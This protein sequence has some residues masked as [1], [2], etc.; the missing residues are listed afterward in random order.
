MNM[1]V[2]LKSRKC[3]ALLV[4]VTIGTGTQAKMRIAHVILIISLNILLHAVKKIT[5]LANIDSFAVLSD[6]II[7]ISIM[8]AIVCVTSPKKDSQM[9]TCSSSLLNLLFSFQS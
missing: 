5:S 7:G 3:E 8:A 2:V 4:N 6:H 1:R 9:R